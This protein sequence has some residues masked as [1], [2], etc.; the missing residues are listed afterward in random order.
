MQINRE[1][2]KRYAAFQSIHVPTPKQ[3]VHKKDAEGV[4]H[5]ITHPA[6]P[7][8]DKGLM[9]L[10]GDGIDHG[11]DSRK[12]EGLTRNHDWLEGPE[13]EEIEDSVFR[14]MGPFFDKKINGAKVGKLRAW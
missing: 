7:E 3:K 8:R 9:V 14:D 10:V 12:N 5:D 1:C 13:E 11:D 2:G 4:N 6:I